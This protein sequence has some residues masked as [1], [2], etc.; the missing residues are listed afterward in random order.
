MRGE[1]METTTCLGC[2]C[3]QGGRSHDWTLFSAKGGDLL[4]EDGPQQLT[5]EE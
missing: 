1:I 2:R 4:T 5:E 3:N